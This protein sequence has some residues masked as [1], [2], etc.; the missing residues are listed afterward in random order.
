[1]KQKR[2]LTLNWDEDEIQD[3]DYLQEEANEAGQ[4]LDE[5]VKSVL[6][7]RKHRRLSEDNTYDWHILMVINQISW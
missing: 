7:I 4:Y 1:M 6:R 2:S 3:Y 5:Y